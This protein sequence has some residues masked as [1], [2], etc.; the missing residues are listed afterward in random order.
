M[1]D[2]AQKRP[3]WTGV[4]QGLSCRFSRDILYYGRKSLLSQ[5]F[6]ISKQMLTNTFDIITAEDP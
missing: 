4:I 2:A 6:K 1:K 3:R 5:T